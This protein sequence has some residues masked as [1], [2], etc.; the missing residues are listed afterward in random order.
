M[1]ADLLALQ[2]RGYLLLEGDRGCHKYIKL[3]LGN[4]QVGFIG[5]SLFNQAGVAMEETANLLGNCSIRFKARLIKNQRRTALSCD[6]ERRCGMDAIHSY[7]RYDSS[8][9][10]L[11][12]FS[13]GLAKI[14]G[15]IPLLS[16][17]R[18]CIHGDIDDLA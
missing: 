6:T 2:G 3:V 14:R 1:D 15:M 12:S 8:L 7:S 13:K 17:S 18:A 11:A 10:G 16:K 9:L 4:I 5:R